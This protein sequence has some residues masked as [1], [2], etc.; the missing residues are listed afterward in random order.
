M[1]KKAREIPAGK[2]K[3]LCLKLMDDVQRD[4]TQIVITKRGIPVAKLVPVDE[5]ALDLFGFLEGDIEIIGDIMA[6]LPEKWEADA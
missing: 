3:A 5:V 1:K 4:R 2:F 6:P